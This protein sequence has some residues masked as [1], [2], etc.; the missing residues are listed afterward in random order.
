MKLYYSLILIVIFLFQTS[1]LLAENNSQCEWMPDPFEY[2]S[3]DELLNKEEGKIKTMP[4]NCWYVFAIKDNIELYKS[5]EKKTK[6]KLSRE[7]E[8]L[9]RFKVT[10]KIKNDI[11]VENDSDTAISG[12]GAL[13]DFVSLSQACKRD[14]RISYKALIVNKVKD[15]KEEFNNKLIARCSPSPEARQNGNYINVLNI[16]YIYSFYPNIK[17]PTYLLIGNKSYYH[18]FYETIEE[19]Q[20]KK[21]S[22]NNVILGWIPFDRAMLWN[23]R[24]AFKPNKNRIHPIYYFHKKEY[25][26]DYYSNYSNDITPTCDNIPTCK[27]NSDHILV[28]HPDKV[29]KI[30]K[31]ST[32][33]E[34]Y[35]N[36]FETK[37]WPQGAFQ[38]P[39]IDE[40][41]ED[42]SF[43][44]A[45]EKDIFCI[46]IPAA[47][48]PLLE[49]I[50]MPT[51][52]DIV[53]LI[54]ATKS[55]SNFIPLVIEIVS[56]IM[57]KFYQKR[58]DSIKRND[59][60]FGIFVYRDPVCE[61][62]GVEEV[63]TLIDLT[64]NEKDISSALKD[65]NIPICHENEESAA[66]FVE[67]LYRGI[68]ETINRADWQPDSMRKIIVIGDAGDIKNVDTVD[69]S[70]LSLT[71]KKIADLL[72]KK[73][74]SIS[75][76]QIIDNKIEKYKFEQ[77]RKFVEAQQ[78]FCKNIC[79]IINRI[80]QNEK[81][82]LERFREPLQDEFDEI[83]NNFKQLINKTDDIINSSD[84]CVP[85]SESRWSLDCLDVD[86][87]DESYKFDLGQKVRI[88]TK[89]L[90]QQLYQTKDI[91]N[92]IIT[93]DK[94]VYSTLSDQ[95]DKIYKPQLVPGVLEKLVKRIGKSKARKQDSD[96]IIQLGID[97]LNDYI[98]DDP[99]FFTKAYVLYNT[100]NINFNNH[101]QPQFIKTIFLQENEVEEIYRPL[102]EI[103]ER[104]GGGVTKRFLMELW[105]DLV[106][107]ITGEA[108][109]PA[110]DKQKSKSL[111]EI[112]YNH[113]G[114][115]LPSNHKFL[116][117]TY[118]ELEQGVFKANDYTN[119]RKYFMDCK[120]RL[121]KILGS[122]NESYNIFE[123][124]YYWLENSDLP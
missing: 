114:I 45:F 42:K 11:Y 74:I 80:S 97:A 72:S 63:E 20:Y 78:F 121:E 109:K 33:P 95:S 13:T 56:D 66:Y 40:E 25:L 7:I 23:T 35:T 29:K 1:L 12:W 113:K 122:N 3:P 47:K 54:D 30:Q 32:E 44:K 84:I 15:M 5:Q 94:I 123:D 17:N 59:L 57:N 26:I 104:R 73:N 52:R 6:K 43:K 68:E 115:K 110:A 18:S 119:F 85:I 75:A 107:A 14:N 79:S 62:I 60:R 93:K 100:P 28:I 117:V 108:F 9:E 4:L 65:I 91:L 36:I 90:S 2:N 106:L 49:N 16:A 111:Q 76:I 61:F 98:R 103:I 34:I 105:K 31:S 38:F 86:L 118:K 101:K 58:E 69:N 96:D 55:M 48:S 102:V 89:E 92:K 41:V 120:K 10:D 8:F 46:G 71:S 77:Q 50:K 53:F 88:L 21:D 82:K 112:F 37:E 24:E 67:S 22:I 83:D 124:K 19:V 99:K 116:T 39:I 27:K 81:K 87:D 64:K 51:G 70:I